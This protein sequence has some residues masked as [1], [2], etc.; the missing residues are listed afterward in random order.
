[1]QV[2][3]RQWRGCAV[4]WRKSYVFLMVL[5]CFGQWSLAQEP[6]ENLDDYRGTLIRLAALVVEARQAPVDHSLIERIGDHGD[7]LYIAPLID[8]AYF[9]ANPEG[10]RAIVDALEQ[11]S[12]QPREIGWRGYFEWAGRTDVAPPPHYAEFKGLL[13]ATVIDPEFA[14]FFPVDAAETAQVNLVEVV[15]GGVSVDG[16]PS[17]VNARQI[18]PEEAAAE[19]E[20]LPQY[21]R[22]DD[23]RYPAADELVFGVALDGD[24][25]AYPL[26]LLNWHEMFNDVIGQ[27]DLFDEPDGER[28]CGF[29]APEVVSIQQRSDEWLQIEGRSAGC[30]ATGWLREADMAIDGDTA[31]VRGRPVMLAY[32][33]LCGAGILYDIAL[34][35]LE[36]VD[37]NGERQFQQDVALE[38][39][40]TGMLMRSNKL[41]YDRLTDTVWNALTGRPAFGPLAESGIELPLLPVV[42]SDWASWLAE[43][44]E[45]SVLSLATGVSRPYRNGAAYARYFNDPEYI[46]FPVWQQDESQQ[47]NKEMIFGLR[48]AGKAIAYPLEHILP[49]GI[50]LDVVGG[51]PLLLLAKATPERDFFEPGGAVVRAYEREAASQTFTWDVATNRLTDQDGAQ[52]HITEEALVGPGGAE[53]ARIAGHLAFWFGWYSYFPETE[54]FE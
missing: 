16:I 54:V 8:A 26:R 17:L 30:P 38:F 45:T 15:W 22:E 33:T 48:I 40:S 32:C 9:M 39:G 27:A 44:P 1:M 13:Y 28:L 46:M 14:R 7:P 31:Q 41:M 53:L 29:R 6:G 24:A 3:F 35:R 25:R 18:T 50:T 12:G 49:A 10:N 19:G 11:L 34:P 5:L 43:H 42:V 4:M 37:A 21:C 47:A 2:G 23:C 20:R 51:Q 52:W 36:Y